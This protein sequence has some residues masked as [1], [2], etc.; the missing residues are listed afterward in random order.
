MR[1]V[2]ITA[3]LRGA[4][5]TETIFSCIDPLLPDYLKTNQTSFRRTIERPLQ[6]I[7]LERFRELEEGDILFIDST[8]V[9]RF[10][11]DVVYEILEIMPLLRPGVIIH[12]HDIFYPNDYPERWLQ[13]YRF[14]WSE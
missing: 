13:N 11:S 14:F 10:D 7:P 2:I 4:G 5:M 9:V 1:T 3:A 12:V 8:H 6:E